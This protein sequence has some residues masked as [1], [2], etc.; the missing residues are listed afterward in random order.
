MCKFLIL[1][2]FDAEAYHSTSLFQISKCPWNYSYTH[3]DDIDRNTGDV[4]SDVIVFDEKN[5]VKKYALIQTIAT[6]IRGDRVETNSGGENIIVDGP[7]IVLTSPNGLYQ[8]VLEP[9]C[10]LKSQDVTTGQI[11]WA[12]F[13]SD[14]MQSRTCNGGC[15]NPMLRIRGSGKIQIR[16]DTCYGNKEVWK[17][18][19]TDGN[20][21]YPVTFSLSNS[22]KPIVR[23]NSD[24]VT[25]WSP[26]EGVTG[27]LVPFVP[28]VHS[29]D[30]S[31]YF[32]IRPDGNAVVYKDDKV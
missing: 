22:G 7:G 9:N 27:H 30:K 15:W 26:P 11:V 6:N 1:C 21:P 16:G 13:S 25:I 23:Q 14:L 8:L 12:V 19:T 28:V 10:E 32:I 31:A 4:D 5:L 2:A 29:E 20:N 3:S 18:Y 24:G 17:T